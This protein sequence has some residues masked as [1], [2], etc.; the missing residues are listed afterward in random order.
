MNASVTD[1][2]PDNENPPIEDEEG[3]P[4]PPLDEG[5]LFATQTTSIQLSEVW[6]IKFWMIY[7]RSFLIEA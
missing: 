4:S 7:C 2:S 3:L 6:H 1:N 5:A